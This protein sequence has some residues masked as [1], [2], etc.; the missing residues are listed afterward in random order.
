MPDL[1]QRLSQY[2]FARLRVECRVCE[3]RGSYSIAKLAERYGAEI[4]F[5]ALMLILTRS[6]Q[7]QRG[8]RDRPPRQY[9]QRCL[10]FLPDLQDPEP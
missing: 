5:E 9:Q 1:P 8:P 10:A 2:P 4:G 7:W 3:R 6:C